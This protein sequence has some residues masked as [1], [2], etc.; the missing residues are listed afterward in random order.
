[1]AV[2]FLLYVVAEVAAVWA[3]ASLIG[4][5]PTLGLLLL[6][7]FV[8]S[9]LARREGGKAA[10][11]F[12]MS[13]RAGK[14]AHTE[15]TDGMLVGLGGMLILVPGFVTDVFGLLLLLPPTRGLFRKAWLRRIERRAPL[16]RQRPG[17]DRVIVVDSEVVEEQRPN[18]DPPGRPIIDSQ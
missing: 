9:W 13:A 5:L 17:P 15:I 1:M 8:G 7:A 12:M 10:N 18:Q 4:F 16:G 3:V 6:G 11:A 2:F 14:P